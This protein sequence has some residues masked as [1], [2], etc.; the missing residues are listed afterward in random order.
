MSQWAQWQRQLH[1]VCNKS[2]AIARLKAMFVSPQFIGAMQLQV[3]KAVRRVPFHNLADPAQRNSMYPQLVLNESSL[4]YRLRLNRA[5]LK[6]QPRWR[7]RLKIFRA[8]K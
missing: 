4:T 2:S 7:N 8:G 6:T 3:D 1:R 5:N